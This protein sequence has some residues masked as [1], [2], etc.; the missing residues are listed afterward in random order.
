MVDVGDITD[1]GASNMVAWELDAI[2]PV[3]V[4]VC[5]CVCVWASEYVNVCLDILYLF[6]RGACEAT[7]SIVVPW[8]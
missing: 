6:A 8:Y 3:C 5:V 7:E 1:A 4:C 2:S